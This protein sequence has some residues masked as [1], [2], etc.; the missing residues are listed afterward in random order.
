MQFVCVKKIVKP[1]DLPLLRKT[2]PALERSLSF[3]HY[4]ID[5]QVAMQRLQVTAVVSLGGGFAA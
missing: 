3:L 5:A 4:V 1:G 2:C